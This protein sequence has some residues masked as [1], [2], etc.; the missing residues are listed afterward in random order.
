MMREKKTK[1][2]F[3]KA[4]SVR[5]S[6]LLKSKLLKQSRTTLKKEK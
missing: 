4:F 2:K 5:Q 3:Q 1:L 6:K